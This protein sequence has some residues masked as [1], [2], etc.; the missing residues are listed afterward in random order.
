MVDDA[1]GETDVD[2]W[3]GCWEDRW[4]VGSSIASRLSSRPFHR[5]SVAVWLG[6]PLF[7]L[8]IR[9]RVA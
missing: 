9:G 1:D 5:F 4:Y 7:A 3:A 8:W 2:G 6:L